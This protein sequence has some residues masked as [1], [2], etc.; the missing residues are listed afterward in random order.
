LL[1]VLVQKECQQDCVSINGQSVLG[2]SKLQLETQTVQA[3]KPGFSQTD[4]FDT[5]I[6]D[7]EVSAHGT[8]VQK[9]GTV[10][11]EIVL[12][13]KVVALNGQSLQVDQSVQQV[14]QVFEDGRVECSGKKPQQHPHFGHHKQHHLRSTEHVKPA[15][16]KRLLGWILVLG[17]AVLAAFYFLVQSVL[18]FWTPYEPLSDEEV[19]EQL[20]KKMEEL[21]PYDPEFKA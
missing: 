15:C 3:Y 10:V 14:F 16:K 20:D 1:S 6:V 5:G 19:V 7:I 11:R 8:Q 17:V 13:E 12:E 21:P 9:H 18:A 2:I 4:A